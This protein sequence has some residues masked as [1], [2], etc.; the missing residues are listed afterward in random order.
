MAVILDRVSPLLAKLCISILFVLI[1]DASFVFSFEFSPAILKLS[2]NKKNTYIKV[3]NSDK[4]KKMFIQSRLVK[5]TINSGSEKDVYEESD[6]IIFFPKLVE[7]N[8][9]KESIIRLG[10]RKETFPE[11]EKAYRLFIKQLPITEPG[12]NQLPVAFEIGVPVFVLKSF[13]P[14]TIIYDYSICGSE[15]S[16]A[17]KFSNKSN[18]H[19]RPLQM[20]IF[21]TDVK[22]NIVWQGEQQGWY[23]FPN[24]ELTYEYLPEIK[25]TDVIDNIS[26]SVYFRNRPDPVEKNFSFKSLKSCD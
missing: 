20:K 19:F 15:K 21:L 5:W 12:K 16:L 8:P 18:Q 22:S 6:D 10:W 11:I 24:R 7:I 2:E 23:V 26:I 4:N 9:G 25:P 1:I 13:S 3:R 14:N 17:L